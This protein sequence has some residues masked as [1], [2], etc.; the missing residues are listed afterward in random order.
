[1]AGD[2]APP[3]SLTAPA[4]EAGGD[5]EK[6]GE[7][8][9]DDEDDED[10]DI[11]LGEA[12]G[13]K[14]GASDD[15]D[16]DLDIVLGEAAG[17]EAP[18]QPGTRPAAASV[19]VKGE[20]KAI[21]IAEAPPAKQGPAA[22]ANSQFRWSRDGKE[23][24][25]ARPPP[26]PPGAEPGS[27]SGFTPMMHPNPTARPIWMPYVPPTEHKDAAF[28]SQAK[29]GQ[30]IKLP[31]QTRVAPEEYKEFLNLGH[32][33]LFEVDLN[34]VVET[35]WREVTAKRTDY[36]NY[37]LDEQGWMRYCETVKKYRL[38]FTMQGKI[39]TQPAGWGRG[40]GM[41]RRGGGYGN[42]GG[43]SDMPAELRAAF[44]QSQRDE[45]S[46][47]F[48]PGT[49]R[50]A[51]GHMMGIKA[52][53]TVYTDPKTGKEVAPLTSD[54]LE[55]IKRQKMERPAG[56]GYG[57]GGYGGRGGRGPPSWREDRECDSRDW[58]HSGRGGRGGGGYQG[59]DD[60]TYASVL[61]GGDDG[62]RPPP[63]PSPD[64]RRESY[65]RDRRGGGGGGGGYRDE[66]RRD[67]DRSPDRRR[68]RDYG[69]D[70]RDRDRDR[71]RGRDRDRR[72]GYRR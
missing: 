66:Y 26:R 7:P 36:F 72:D 18:Q 44:Q 19:P 45:L 55:K 17:G 47:G 22:P 42:Y 23:E 48:E 69:R 2:S 33:E 8:G 1:M 62:G 12:A 58:Q 68:E 30:P 9:G 50:E 20:G 53:D 43:Q 39:E 5:G 11:V 13:G 28:P 37:D 52:V 34:R 38:E 31:G 14:E 21:E 27:M 29:P 67:R 16:D 56:R 60:T 35:P 49:S 25:P 59:N 65:E 64:R 46:A 15:D 70:R 3:V 63:R 61:A 10:F 71:D 54:M 24:P 41:G 32:G 57:G 51:S 40:G 4:M 6:G